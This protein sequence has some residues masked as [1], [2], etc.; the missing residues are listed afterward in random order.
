M[1]A[2]ATLLLMPLCAMVYLD[3]MGRKFKEALSRTTMDEFGKV[4]DSLAGAAVF[5]QNMNT[6]FQMTQDLDFRLDANQR[7]YE[8]SV[9]AADGHLAAATQELGASVAELTTFLHYL[10]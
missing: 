8:R 3:R 1:G 6:Q 5:L 7:S 4:S 10:T 9:A 2:A